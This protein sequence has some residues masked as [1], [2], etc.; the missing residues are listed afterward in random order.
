M[1]KEKDTL[2]LAKLSARIDELETRLIEL[3][4]CAPATLRALSLTDVLAAV[5]ED[6]F[7][8]FEVLETWHKIGR[9]F[10]AGEI[11]YADRQPMLKHFV[12]SGLKIGVP[13][14]HKEY[15][16][17]LKA[18]RTAARELAEAQVAVAASSVAAAKA[19]LELAFKEDDDAI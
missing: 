16:E 2:S 15:V 5:E 4:A 10:S 11:I 13:R 6:P 7:C 14:N 9:K 1:S 8:R 18:E 3:E 17:Q 12:T 19:Q